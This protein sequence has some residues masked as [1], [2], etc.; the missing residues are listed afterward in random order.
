MTELR[1]FLPCSQQF[2]PKV[3]V[4]KLVWVIHDKF[5]S[6]KTN[7]IHL[8][9]EK[10]GKEKSH[11]SHLNGITSSFIASL[12]V[13]CLLFV[14]NINLVFTILCK[15]PYRYFEQKCFTV[16]L[17]NL[18]SRKKKFLHI[19][20]QPPSWLIQCAE[21][22]LKPCLVF[23]GLRSAIVSLLNLHNVAW[24]EKNNLFNCIDEHL[25]TNWGHHFFQLKKAFLLKIF[26]L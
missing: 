3:H 2:N 9:L 1:W 23:R 19:I 25:R 20:I 22:L 21:R 24:K 14:V 5:T 8:W 26:S 6:Q 10:V 17:C 7:S 11:K 15:C 16:S 18:W 4:F 12:V 13:K